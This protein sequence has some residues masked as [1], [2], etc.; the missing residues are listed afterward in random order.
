MAQELDV[1]PSPPITFLL[2]FH[3]IFWLKVKQEVS[4]DNVTQV[5]APAVC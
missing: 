2:F 5:S 1:A 4:S 3:G